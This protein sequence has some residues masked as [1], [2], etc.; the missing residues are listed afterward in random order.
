MSKKNTLPNVDINKVMKTVEGTDVKPPIVSNKREHKLNF[1]PVDEV[2]YEVI[3]FD[4]PKL[5]EQV[6]K[7]YPEMTNEFKR[8]MF[9]QYELFCKKQ[10]NYGPDNI[11]AGTKLVTDEEVKLSLTGLFFRIND[12]LITAPNNDRI[13]DGITRKSIIQIAKDNDIDI[14]VRPI[15]VSEVVEASKKGTLL[16]MFG[17]GTAVVVSPIKSFG[18]QGVNY[19]LPVIEN[20]LSTLLKEKIT[21]IQYNLS[22]DPHGWR[23]AVD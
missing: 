14:E 12:K 8:I 19:K 17:S 15:K 9:T 2:E 3:Q 16:E 13:L 20:P 4:D 6:E 1:K 18:Y 7:E 10:S 22:E 21:S 11:A 5:I 23:L